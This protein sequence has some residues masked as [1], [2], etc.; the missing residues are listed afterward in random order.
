MIFI[1]IS[2]NTPKI[3]PIK[4]IVESINIFSF[5]FLFVLNNTNIPIPAPVKSPD[6]KDANEI[7]L[8]KNNS[9]SITDEAQFGISPI[10]LV[11]NGASILSFRNNL[12][13]KFVPPY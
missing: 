7:A 1:I 12:F 4:Y 2:N 5:L 6:I 11:K 8:L 10:K 13:N 3:T 9:V